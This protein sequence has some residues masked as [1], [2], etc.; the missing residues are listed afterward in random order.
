MENIRRKQ[1]YSPAKLLTAL[2]SKLP[3]MCQYCNYGFSEG[4][5]KLIEYDDVYQEAMR[6][7][8]QSTYGF[9][10]DWDEL[11]EEVY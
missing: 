6:A 10:E 7:E 5:E 9:H 11:S 4:W 1:N 3:A 2:S 8:S